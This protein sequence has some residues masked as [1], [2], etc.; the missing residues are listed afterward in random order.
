MASVNLFTAE[1]MQTIED[2]TVV[3]GLVDVNGDLI[4]YKRDGSPIN[5]GLVRGTNGADGAVGADG[6]QGPPGPYGIAP[7]STTPPSSP[8]NGSFWVDSDTGTLYVWYVDT[9]G[10]QWIEA[11]G[12]VTGPIVDRVTALETPN[13]YTQVDTTS[14]SAGTGWTAGALWPTV[15]N[16]KAGSLVSIFYHV[17]MRNDSTVWG[18]GYSE[19]MVSI[20]GTAWKSFGTTGF[21]AVMEYGQSIGIWNTN[22]LLNVVDEG[23]NTD[24]SLRFQFYFKSYDGTV[25][26]NS[27]NDLANAGSGAGVRMA[28]NNGN[29]N[30]THIIVKEIPRG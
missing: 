22:Y 23:I 10:G 26:M 24:F 29:Q 28:G 7:P 20:N 9:N 13:V 27:G 2:T 12:G 5:A 11:G 6:P 25:T 17:A 21:G 15:S 1:R 8:V 14:R 19:L 30:Y 18:G 4:L 16:F 3:S